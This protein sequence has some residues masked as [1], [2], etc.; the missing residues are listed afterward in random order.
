MQKVIVRRRTPRLG[1][2]YHRDGGTP[3]RQGRAKR[4]NSRTTL[5][6]HRTG[7]LSQPLDIISA[8]QYSDSCDDIDFFT[9]DKYPKRKTDAVTRLYSGNG[10]TV[11]R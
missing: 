7:F 9:E 1:G 3:I 5:R 6:V 8:A 10:V 2:G 4:Q 11:R